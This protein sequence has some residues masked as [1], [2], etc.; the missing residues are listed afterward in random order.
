ME[1]NWFFLAFFAPFLWAVVSVIDTYLVHS[2][3]EDEYEGAIISGIFQLVPWLLVLLGVIDFAPLGAVQT[4]L[5]ML[6]G[7]L[8][9]F[10][11]FCYFKALFVSNDVSL[12]QILWN[13][14]IPIVPFI[15]WLFI[16]EILMPIHYAGIG[17]AFCG[18]LVFLLNGKI[19]SREMSKVFLLMFVAV[20]LL[21]S[22]MVMSKAVYENTTD[23]WS[24]FLLFS[25][26]ATVAAGLL[27]L[28]DK[29]KFR[30]RTEKIAQLSG[31]YFFIFLLAES[32]ALLGILASHRA[33][34]LSPSVSFVATIESLDPVFVM[35]IS[36]VLVLFFKMTGNN[37][38]K[39]AYQ[40]QFSD[41]YRKIFA[42]LIMASG[43][44]MIS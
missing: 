22:S 33:I 30:E 18:V 13:L 44:Y 11:V 37:D 1:I 34:D 24:V 20:V 41:P 6:A 42:M 40:K 31:K 43:I 15:A 14:S 8:F 25:L 3:Y 9:L 38:I 4:A 19:V 36:F 39:Q 26:G 7:L 32:L 35:I 27:L 12:M 2:I 5:A 29:K 28:V 21:S 10:A 23:F 16:G 17:L